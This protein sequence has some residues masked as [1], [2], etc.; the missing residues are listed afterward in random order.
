MIWWLISSSNLSLG[1]R[2]YILDGD[3]IRHGLSNDLGFKD[4][5][6]LENIRW[7]GEVAK[8]MVDAGIV[9]I[10]AFISPFGA[11]R[12]MARDLFDYGEFIEDFVDVPLEVAEKR[13]PKGLYR[14]AREGKLPNF[15]G[16]ESPCEPPENP[17]I[18]VQSDKMKVE[19]IDL[20]IRQYTKI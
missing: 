15:T 8:L 10:T 16:I 14:K 1:V 17:E 6:R 3:N 19:E 18:I 2:T 5:D 12:R 20:T 7:V 11:E 9:V 13:D 4:S